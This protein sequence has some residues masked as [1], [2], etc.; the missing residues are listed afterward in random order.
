MDVA[1]SLQDFIR[2]IPVPE[3]IVSRSHLIQKVSVG[4]L[5]M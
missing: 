4:G 1:K 2:P 5:F 3:N